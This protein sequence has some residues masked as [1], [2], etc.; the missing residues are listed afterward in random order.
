MRR[1]LILGLLLLSLPSLAQEKGTVKQQMGRIEAAYG[2]YFVYDATLPVSEPAGWMVDTTQS[3]QKNLRALFDDTDITWRMWKQ[4]VVLTRTAPEPCP[5]PTLAWPEPAYTMRVDTLREAIKI[6]RQ[7]DCL[8][9][10]STWIDP[11][12]SQKIVTPLGG[13]DAF[14]FVQ[15]QPGVAMGGEGTTAM[16]VRGGD[17]GANLVTLDGVPIYGANHLMGLASALPDDIIGTSEFRVGGFRSDEGNLTASHLRLQSYSG[18]FERF[19]SRISVNPFFVSASLSTPVV[20]EK[21][22]LLASVRYSP[23]GLEY[24]AF[25]DLINRHQTTFTDYEAM[26]GDI[27]GKLTWKPN[28]RNEVALSFFGSEDENRFN[29]GLYM[30]DSWESLGWSNI[31]ANLSWDSCDALGF[32]CIHTAVSYNRHLWKERLDY[33]YIDWAPTTS[34]HSDRLIFSCLD[35]WIFRTSATK[36]LDRWSFVVGAALRSAR[37]NPCAQRMEYSTRH[38]TNPEWLKLFPNLNDVDHLSHVLLPSFHGEAVYTIPER[39][40]VRLSLRGNGYF[41]HEEKKEGRTRWFHPEAS[42]TARVWLIPQVGLETTVDYL[43]QYYHFLEVRPTGWALDPIVPASDDLQPERVKQA[44][45]GLFGGSGSHTFRAGAFYKQMDGLV[46]YRKAA[47][48]FNEDETGIYSD[49]GDLPYTNL[50]SGEGSAYGAELLYDKTGRDLSWHLAYSWSKA[51]R[52]FEKLNNGEVFPARYD[53]RHVLNAQVEWKGLTAAFVFQSGHYETVS[54]AQLIKLQH[55]YANREMIRC[56]MSNLRVPAHIRLD[57][58]Y[59]LSFRSGQV[60]PVSHNLTFGVYNVFN[61]HN[62]SMLTFDANAGT[63]K[64]I[65]FFPI[66]P[67]ISYVMEL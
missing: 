56:A 67:S 64:Y 62:P 58:G 40:Q 8:S 28:A 60:H 47:S 24:K 35:E 20:K 13:G 55:S 37:L 16:F 51:D 53:R 19:R 41:M 23:V 12:Q 14:R 43:T 66:M 57:L 5:C 22:S 59:R 33:W 9:A 49:R 15:A 11:V 46:Y 52:H 6:A 48:I 17:M 42:L 44:Y 36:R 50:F 21:L 2:V 61:R 38:A 31:A 18:D 32:D 39:F 54:A 45:F 65:S 34:M 63:W 7:Y 4:Y 3:L 10:G 26:V 27:Y 25:K 29:T 30:G 1:I